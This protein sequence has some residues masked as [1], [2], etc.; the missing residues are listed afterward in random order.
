MGENSKIEWTD[1]T[2]NPWIGCT[3]VSPG[4]AHCY[5][6]SLSKRTGLAVWG[7]NGTRRVTSH[8]NWL[9]PFKWARDAEK[10]GV[11]K[12]VFCASLADVFEDRDDLVA[13]RHRLWKLIHETRRSLD[14]LLLTKR[15]EN[16][17]TVP[18]ALTDLW[19]GV[20]VENRKAK[21]RINHLRMVPAAVRFLSVEPLLE[22]LGEIDL[23]GIGWVIVG[24][25]SGAGARPMRP[26][27]ARSIREQ[28]IAASVPFFFKQW[29]EWL[30]D[31]QN[32]AIGGSSGDTQA[33]RVGKKAAGSLLY[34]FEWK[35]FPAVAR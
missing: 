35:Q 4:C 34:G 33:I 31:S 19:L 3:K 15:P 10:L 17:D 29:G 30:P 32:H 20:S 12:R 8:E 1:H 24:G 14:W 16:F 13:P 21:E 6:E 11:R 2:F 26:D 7:D 28:C 22:D 5:A 9:K 18:L 23:T 27:W 25:E